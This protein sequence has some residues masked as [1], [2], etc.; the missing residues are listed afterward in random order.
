MLTTP[1]CRVG[2][3]YATSRLL[4]RK[5]NQIFIYLFILEIPQAMKKLKIRTTAYT[6]LSHP[7]FP[8][9][10]GTIIKAIIS[11]PELFPNIPVE[12]PV[13]Q[14]AAKLM[15]N[16]TSRASLGGV[17]DRGNRNRQRSYL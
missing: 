10:F 8:L 17:I 1:Y 15:W 7:K 16:T 9:E 13:L 2:A 12:P 4:S 11:Q 3:T 5:M 6:Y 14:E